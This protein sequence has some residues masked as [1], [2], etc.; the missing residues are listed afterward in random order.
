MKNHNAYVGGVADCYYSRRYGKDMWI[1]YKYIAKLPVKADIDLTK[2]VTGLQ[3]AWLHERHVDG[4]NVAVIV[5]SPEGGVIFRADER[6]IIS[7]AEFKKRIISDAEIANWI[8]AQT[9][10][11]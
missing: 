4:R 5:G 1:E 3:Q 6:W 9:T 2:I 11:K 8:V 7:P 10:G